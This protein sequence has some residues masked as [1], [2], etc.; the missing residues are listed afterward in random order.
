MAS[1]LTEGSIDFKSCAY[2]RKEQADRLQKGFA[3]EG[4]VLISHKATIGVTAIVPK[5]DDY[6]M[7]TPQVTYYRIL[8]RKVLNNVFLKAVFDSPLFQTQFRRVAAD[9]S[10]RDY[11]GITKQRNL[12]VVL[13]SLEEQLEI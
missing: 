4:D 1:D 5:V 8:D 12:F 6:V 13:P 7:L 10:T 2:L 11:I 9:G 3:R